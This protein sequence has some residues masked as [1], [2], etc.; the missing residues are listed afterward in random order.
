MPSEWE[1]EELARHL[2][3]LDDE[4]TDEMFEEAVLEK[5]NTDF[6]TFLHIAAALAP[7]CNVW[8]SPLTDATYRGFAADGLALVKM[9]VESEDD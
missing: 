4:A 8:K 7:L 9:K 5:F 2:C 6:E 1:Y 3:G